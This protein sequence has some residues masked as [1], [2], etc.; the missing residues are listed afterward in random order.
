MVCRR[1][2][3]WNVGEE[4]GLATM[5]WARSA[6]GHQTPEGLSAAVPV[7]DELKDLGEELFRDDGEDDC[8]TSRPFCSKTIPDPAMKRGR[9]ALEL[10]SPPPKKLALMGEFGVLLRVIWAR[11]DRPLRDFSGD[12]RKCGLCRAMSRSLLISLGI[13]NGS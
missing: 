13:A 3:V 11:G 2:G 7:S 6:A 9:L 10:L 4:A 12:T 5:S 1:P 8:K